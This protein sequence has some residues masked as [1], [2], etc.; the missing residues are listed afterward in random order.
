MAN[1]VGTAGY[2]IT[3]LASYGAA[4]TLFGPQRQG[5]GNTVTG[6]GQMVGDVA[7]AGGYAVASTF[8]P[9]TAYNAYGESMHNLGLVGDQL[10]GGGNSAGYRVGYTG[11]NVASLYLGGQ[12]GQLGRGG[13][14]AKI[15]VPVGQTL[16]AGGRE[17]I[18]AE[19]AATEGEGLLYGKYRA[20]SFEGRRV[21]TQDID[22]GE[23][24]FV[25]PKFV[26]KAIRER[27]KAG[28][29]NLDLMRG[30]KAPIGPD[31]RAMNLHHIIG[32][33]PGPM[34]E[35][36]GSVHSRYQGPLHGIIEDGQ[37]F[38]KVLGLEDAYDQFRGR[39]WKWRA[40][41]FIN[42]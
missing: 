34:V 9:D 13:R 24:S 2:G 31:G 29:S 14:L 6:L 27:I 7:N 37:S 12:I 17:R 25:D 38:R 42:E 30:G 5:L 1:T 19:I 10:T 16:N 11:L 23:P 32:D 3:S 35:L 4:E 20:Q 41:Q 40:S 22:I 28:A 33:E 39:Y 8:D 18:V 15:T 36:E 21:F 26:G